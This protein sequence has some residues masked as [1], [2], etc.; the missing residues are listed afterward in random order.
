MTKREKC[1]ECLGVAASGTSG[2]GAPAN[3]SGRM[4]PRAITGLTRMTAM[5]TDLEKV[6]RAETPA[7]MIEAD[8]VIAQRRARFESCGDLVTPLQSER[9]APGSQQDALH[10]SK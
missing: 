3:N 8:L 7:A 4:K 5:P 6:P 2:L 9:R 10:L 1:H